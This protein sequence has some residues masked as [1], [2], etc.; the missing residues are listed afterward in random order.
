MGVPTRTPDTYCHP[1]E[2]RGT[3]GGGRGRAG[4]CEEEGG[5]WHDGGFD[6]LC[7]G[8][9]NAVTGCGGGGRSVRIAKWGGRVTSWKNSRR[10]QK[11]CITTQQLPFFP[12]H[13]HCTNQIYESLVWFRYVS[14]KVVDEAC[15]NTIILHIIKAI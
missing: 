11:V 3:G 7:E 1:D 13:T 14:V 10:C 9:S 12:H 15:N 4:G 2:V 6:T 5:L 8:I